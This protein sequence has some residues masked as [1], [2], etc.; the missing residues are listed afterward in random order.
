MKKQIYYLA[1]SLLVALSMASVAEAQSSDYVKARGFASVD[2]VRP[3]DKFKVAIALAIDKGYHVN[4]NKPR[5]KNLIPTAVTFE[6]IAG[7]RINEIKYPA[8]KLIKLK[9]ELGTELVVYEGTIYILADA[10]ADKSIQAGA[11]SM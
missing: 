6:P 1:L 10:E 5:D 7:I 4:S 3:G 2:A 8:S 9:D 11:A